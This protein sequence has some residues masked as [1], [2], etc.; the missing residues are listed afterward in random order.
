MAKFEYEV[1]DKHLNLY[2]RI[3]TDHAKDVLRFLAQVPVQED[4]ETSVRMAVNKTYEGMTR[5]SEMRIQA[6]DMFSDQ[7]FDYLL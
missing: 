2:D 7:E 3:D 1:R 5:P 4:L 6:K